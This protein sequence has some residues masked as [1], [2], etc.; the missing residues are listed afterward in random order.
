M[1]EPILL[2][3]TD[4]SLLHT[5]AMILQ[6]AGFD[7]VSVQEK[8][9]IERHAERC[10]VGLLLL[11][12]TLDPKA[13]EDAVAA[14]HKHCPDAR[15]LV[16]VKQFGGACTTHYP[17]VNAGDGPAHMLAAI[18]QLLHAAIS[19]NSTASAQPHPRP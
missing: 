4:R 18:E 2:Y 14:V 11:C 10:R 17:V 5:R 16:I 1:H 15:S 8:S 13:R 6:Q 9:E 7:V 19:P 12:H 3:G